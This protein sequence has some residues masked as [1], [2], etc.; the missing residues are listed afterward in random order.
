MLMRLTGIA[1][2]QCPFD[3]VARTT[4]PDISVAVG[5][6]AVAVGKYLQMDN[7]IRMYV[8]GYVVRVMYARP[9]NGVQQR[10]VL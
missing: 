6:G 1:L 4:S 3:L 10:V 2:L 5:T 9:E 8:C 7:R